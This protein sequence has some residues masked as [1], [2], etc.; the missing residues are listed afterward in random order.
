MPKVS[1]FSEI[2]MALLEDLGGN[3][4]C[5]CFASLLRIVRQF[6]KCSIRPPIWTALAYKLSYSILGCSKNDADGRIW[7]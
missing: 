6:W 3:D 4:D 1:D 7:I 2:S 5:F